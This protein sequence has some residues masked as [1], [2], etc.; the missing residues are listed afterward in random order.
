MTASFDMVLGDEW[1]KVLSRREC[2]IAVLVARGM[3]N[4]EVARELG[5]SNG[6]VK[7]HVHSIFQKLGAKSR[8][9]LIIQGEPLSAAE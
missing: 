3:S 7:I 5:L 4:K 1:S 9:S 6:T 8:Y 2:E